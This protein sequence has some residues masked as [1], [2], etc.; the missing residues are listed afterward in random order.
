MKRSELFL[1]VMA[2]AACDLRFERKACRRLQAAR[3]DLSPHQSLPA[4]RFSRTLRIGSMSL[5]AM[6]LRGPKWFHSS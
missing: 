6:P 2:A 1:F 5:E 3:R 4:R